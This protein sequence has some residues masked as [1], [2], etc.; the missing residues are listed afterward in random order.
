[1]SKSAGITGWRLGY[2]AGPEEIVGGMRKLQEQTTS[3]PSSIAQ[4]A[5]VAALSLG[6]SRVADILDDFKKKRDFVCSFLGKMGFDIIP[7][8]GAF[9]VFFDVSKYFSPAIRNSDD[10]CGDLLK[11]AG[12]ALVPGGAFG[13][14]SCVRLSY[15]CGWDELKIGLERMKNFLTAGETM[16]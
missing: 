10:F 12:V 9:Y 1:L 5:G 7:P 6:K 8:D 16:R 2:A 15:A 3:N 14:D 13:D 11:R 4:K